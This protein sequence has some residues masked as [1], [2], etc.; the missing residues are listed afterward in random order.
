MKNRIFALLLAA[1]VLLCAVAQGEDL[2]GAWAMEKGTIQLHEGGTAERY[3]DKPTLT[4]LLA[5]QMDDSGALLL[6]GGARDYVLSWQE[7]DGWLTLTDEH[8]ETTVWFLST[9]EDADAGLQRNADSPLVGVWTQATDDLTAPALA[10]YDDGLYILDDLLGDGAKLE[11]GLYRAVDG[12]LTLYPTL[13]SEYV[14]AEASAETLTLTDAAGKATTWT[15]TERLPFVPTEDELTGAWRAE[16]GAMNTYL[17]GTLTVKPASG[18]SSRIGYALHGS[19]LLLTD[20]EAHFTLRTTA[21]LKDGKLWLSA[22][23]TTDKI[24]ETVLTKEE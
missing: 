18:A 13:D 15:R 1:L 6:Y 17:D 16:D 19:Q 2:A 9:P 10:L 20:S 12:L 7:R 14:A 22:R 21:L 8:A 24:I 11:M 5:W 3:D 4:G 23:D